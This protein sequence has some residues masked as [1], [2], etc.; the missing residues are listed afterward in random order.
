MKGEA[1]GRIG[2]GRGKEKGLHRRIAVGKNLRVVIFGK[3][4]PHLSELG[5]GQ[6]AFGEALGRASGF[7]R[8]WLQCEAV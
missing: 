7:E 5:I 8:V 6:G 4:R 2:A 1:G 3:A